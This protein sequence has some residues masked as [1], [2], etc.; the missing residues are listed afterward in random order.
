[1]T[2]LVAK[3]WRGRNR[4]KLNGLKPE[5]ERK[6]GHG[7]GTVEKRG[8]QGRTMNGWRRDRGR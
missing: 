8:G 3:I 4:G 6:M 7:H 1:V 5:S 2:A